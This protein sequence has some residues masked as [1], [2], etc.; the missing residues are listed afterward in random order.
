MSEMVIKLDGVWKIFDSRAEEA[1]AA[2]SGATAYLVFG[3]VFFAALRYFQGY[4]ANMRYEKQYL[5][6]RAEHDNTTVGLKWSRALFGVLLWLAIVPLTLY[7]FTV[8]K[9]APE[10]EPFTL[11]FPV[12]KKEYFSPIA[13]WM[14]DGFDWLTI[15]GSGVFDGIVRAIR[16]V[17][18]GLET[19]FVDTPWPVVMT[20][21]IVMAWRLAGPRVAVF[22]AASL[23]YLAFLG[24][25]R[26]A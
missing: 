15:H 6:W 1:V 17:L 16:T 9:I 14:E 21:I 20:V 13:N 19:I 24:M 5:T 22:T 23:A 11:G 3:L 26:P 10:L 7:R 25:W 2:A 4:Y 8:G 18:D 12:A